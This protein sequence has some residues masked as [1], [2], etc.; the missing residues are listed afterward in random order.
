MMRSTKTKSELLCFYLPFFIIVIFGIILRLDQFTQQVLLD[1]EWHAIHQLLK[2]HPEKLF[3]TFGH[4]DFSIPL[5]LLYWLQLNLFGLSET[6]MR[7]PMMLAGISTLVAFPLYIRKFFDNKTTLIFSLLLSLSPLLVIYSRTAR[8]YSIT[9][10]LSLVA[11]AAFYKF[12]SVEKSTWKPGLTYVSCAL[13]SAW[14]HLIT[15]PMLVAPF[16]IIG[17]PLILRR[18]WKKTRRVI[19][20]GGLLTAG[21]LILVLPPLLEHPEALVNK[22]GVHTP[23]LRTLYGALFTW[24]GVSSTLLMLTGVLLAITGAR[25]SWQRFPIMPSLIAGI[26]L[27]LVAILLTQPAW[28]RNPLTFSRYLLPMIPL[29]L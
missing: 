11:V 7:W 6:G 5:A 15:L 13:L 19:Y 28:I 14:L 21:L 4:A 18:D 27:T 24:L 29:L 16:I 17:F 20:L 9:L 22:L 23:E 3:L 1:D 25:Q 26:G 8:P 12:V 2:G 10:L